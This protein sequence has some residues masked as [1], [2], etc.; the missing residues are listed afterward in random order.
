VEGLLADVVV[1]LGQYEAPA[2]DQVR[3][4]GRAREHDGRG[5]S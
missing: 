2:V 1:W 5:P 3:P 4:C